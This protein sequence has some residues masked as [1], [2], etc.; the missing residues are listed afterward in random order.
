[1]Y[2]LDTQGTLFFIFQSILMYILYEIHTEKKKQKENY[3]IYIYM[4][5]MHEQRII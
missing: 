5:N 3:L 1:M 2:R 4:R